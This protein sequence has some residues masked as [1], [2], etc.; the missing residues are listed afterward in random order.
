MVHLSREG[1]GGTPIFGRLFCVWRANYGERLELFL[2]IGC[3][4]E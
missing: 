4:F 2:G 3:A 1:G